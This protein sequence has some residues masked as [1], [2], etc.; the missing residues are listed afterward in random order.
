MTIKAKRG[1]A[2]VLAAA[3]TLAPAAGAFAD[4][5]DTPQQHETPLLCAV[6]PTISQ[7]QLHSEP[8]PLSERLGSIPTIGA[9]VPCG[10]VVEGS[11]FSWRPVLH[12]GEVGFAV[13]GAVV[14]TPDLSKLEMTKTAV[15]YS[16]SSFAWIGEFLSGTP[17]VHISPASASSALAELEPGAA[18]TVADVVVDGAPTL[19]GVSKWRPAQLEDGRR[20]FVPDGQLALVPELTAA[21]LTTAVTV[22][23]DTHLFSAPSVESEI[24]GLV[25]EGASIQTGAPFLEWTPVAIDGQV[26]WAF[27]PELTGQE[28]PTEEQS[29][30]WAAVKTK[31]SQWAAAAKDKAT[32]VMDSAK[33]KSSK[34]ESATA[35]SWFARTFPAL[36]TATA[37]VSAIP[38][39][40]AAAISLF[41]TWLAWARARGIRRGLLKL[42]AIPL[43][44]GGAVVSAM[45]IPGAGFFWAIP[46]VTALI[47]GG[48]IARWTAK[49]HGDGLFNGSKLVL[50][51][52]TSR[53]AQAMTASA[54]LIP[55]G[56]ALMTGATPITAA[57]ITI[58]T[59]AAPAGWVGSMRHDDGMPPEGPADQVPAESV[60]GAVSEPGEQAPLPDWRTA[61]GA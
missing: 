56:T 47:A 27:T 24:T 44:T 16:P 55:A 18:V 25:R 1:A 19:G 36:A 23:A 54:I 43:A 31:T 9:T 2:A 11:G 38:A 30:M 15:V 59:A 39:L 52:R 5:A 7:M 35:K 49:L 42:I 28:D 21:A 13:D 6:L 22:G 8:E 3:L 32:D 10:P 53:I 45:L 33:E 50:E 41:G 46:A 40:I 29:S 58:L 17:T 61:S 34:T 12:N 48:A 4:D 57:V 14:E 37:W 51:L 60:P 20:G 26:R